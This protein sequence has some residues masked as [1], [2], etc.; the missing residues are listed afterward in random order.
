MTTSRNDFS[1]F[2]KWILAARPKTLPAA[3]APVI[4]ASALAYCTGHLK[5]GPA[6]AALFGALFLQIGANLANDV[7]D[8]QKGVDTIERLGPLRVT[9]AG[10]LNPSQVKA[11]MWV[12]FGLAVLSGLY[13]FVFSGW[14]VLIIGILSIS[15]ALAYTAG[16]YPLGY[17]GLGELFVFVFFGLVAVNGTYYVQAGFINPLSILVSISI[18][19]LAV[20][21]LVVN[22]LRDISSDRTTGKNTLAVRFGARWARI[23]YLIMIGVAFFLLPVAVLVGSFTP[24]ILIAWLAFPQAVGLVKFVSSKEGRSLNKALAGTGSLE[25]QFA[26]YLSA[27]LILEHLFS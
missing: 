27:G 24:W 8:F 20:C 25:L 11:G 19:L 2:R 3:S 21:I 23:E 9:Q 15:A 22:N 13:L 12:I 5:V 17:H 10:L 6:I 16:P 1:Q 7:Y 4:A 18:G 14:P 26:L